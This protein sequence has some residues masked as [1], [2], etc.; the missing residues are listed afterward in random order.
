MAA[1]SKFYFRVIF[2]CTEW[3][4]EHFERV[5]GVVLRIGFTE[6]NGFLPLDAVRRHLVGVVGASVFD[7][8]Q[9]AYWVLL[10]FT[11]LSFS[12]THEEG[13]LNRAPVFAGL[14]V[15]DAKNEEKK[16]TFPIPWSV[17]NFSTRVDR[18]RS[19]VWW[20]DSTNLSVGRTRQTIWIRPSPFH[21]PF[22]VSTELVPILHKCSITILADFY[23]YYHVLL[24]FFGRDYDGAVVSFE[25]KSGLS[26]MNSSAEETYNC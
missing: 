9:P 5:C 26:S 10:G 17:I 21:Q 23:R 18:S 22:H 12:C 15:C 2:F 19:K 25:N 20:T 13:S 24:W 3:A 14:R 6:E 1:F 8:K 4:T 16:N 11:D 7:T